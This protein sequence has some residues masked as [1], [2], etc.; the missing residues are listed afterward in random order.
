VREGVF[1]NNIWTYGEEITAISSLV[2]FLDTFKT[3]WTTFKWCKRVL[4]R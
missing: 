3:Q 4:C 1:G 2:K